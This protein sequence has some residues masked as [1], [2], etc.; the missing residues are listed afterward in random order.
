M[1]HKGSCVFVPRALVPVSKKDY[2]KL[3]TK[4]QSDFI[5]TW[6]CIDKVER[7]F[8]N[9]Q[10]ANPLKLITPPSIDEITKEDIKCQLASLMCLDLT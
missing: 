1:K 10:A 3:T 6:R 5:L 4:N 7:A 9:K 8:V 2:E